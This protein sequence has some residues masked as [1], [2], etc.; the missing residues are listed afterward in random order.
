MNTEFG[1]FLLQAIDYFARY[2]SIEAKKDMIAAFVNERCIG[3]H[4][5]IFHVMAMYGNKI[6]KHEEEHEEAG[7]SRNKL[8]N[9]NRSD[10]KQFW[11]LLVQNGANVNQLTPDDENYAFCTQ[12]TRKRMSK[13]LLHCFFDQ[14]DALP[15]TMKCEWLQMTGSDLTAWECVMWAMMTKIEH[16]ETL[17]QRMQPYVASLNTNIPVTNQILY[18]PDWAKTMQPAVNGVHWVY[19]TDAIDEPVLCKLVRFSKFMQLH[20]QFEYVMETAQTLLDAGA[21]KTLRNRCSSLDVSGVTASE[22]ALIIA[23]N[24]PPFRLKE[25]NNTDEIQISNLLRLHE[26]LK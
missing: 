10:V 9:Q 21:D 8:G 13:Q 6:L 16:Y 17:F 23:K 7:A 19:R 20:N 2:Y 18:L 1:K 5:S 26:L 24:Q 14:L 15:E 3:S 25:R 11:Q 22:L 12:L 4:L